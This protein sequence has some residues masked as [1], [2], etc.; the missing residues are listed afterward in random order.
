[1]L[2]LSNSTLRTILLS[3]TF[4]DR[5]VTILKNFFEVDGRWIEIRCDALRHEP[6]YSVL[7]SRSNKEKQKTIIDLVR[8]L[9][10][11]GKTLQMPE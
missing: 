3:A 2:L 5:C 7:R 6:R 11:P 4:E 8:K 10:H 9:P 1:M